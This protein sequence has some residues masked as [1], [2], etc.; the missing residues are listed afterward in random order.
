MIEDRRT[1]DCIAMEDLATV[2]DLGA[3][4]PRYDHIQEC[5]RCRALGREFEAF[6]SGR[7]EDLGSEGIAAEAQLTAKLKG[8]L[9]HEFAQ[10]LEKKE[11]RRVPPGTLISSGG[12]SWWFRWRRSL[13]VA[14]TGLAALTVFVIWPNRSADI[15]LRGEGPETISF[16]AA[17]VSWIEDIP[18]RY[19]FTWNS[20]EGADAYDVI[21]YR[22]DLT[23]I[24]RLEAGSRNSTSWEPDASAGHQPLLWRVIGY[25]EGK[26]VFRS[27][28]HLV[29]AP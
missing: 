23:Q 15:V 24:V 16:P 17:T 6:L 22:E 5:P 2:L 27:A 4:D 11:P 18:G 13:I 28:L 20:K 14:G 26:A 21:V 3:G 12:W 25:F 29:P 7:I 8:A 1:S 10:A 19:E 9:D